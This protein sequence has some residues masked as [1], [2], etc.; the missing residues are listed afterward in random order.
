MSLE[1]WL[2]LVTMLAF[3]AASVLPGHAVTGK[4]KAWA[5]F[6]SAAK[7][8]STSNRA[9]GIRALGLLRENPHAREL[10]EAALDDEKPEVRIA[11]AT[12]L[13]Q[14]HA[15]QSI[16]KLQKLLA[17]E[18]VGVVMAAAHS[19]RDLKDNSSAYAVYYDVLTGAK[20]GDGPIAQQLDTLRNPRELAK[21]GFEEGIGYIPFAGIGWDAWRYTHKKD[22]NPVRAVAA[23]L[24]AHDPDPATGVAL[25][26]AM[27]DKD[28]IVRAAAIEALAQRGDPSVVGKIEFKLF[29]V[30]AH[31]RYTAAAAVI[32]LSALTQRE[33]ANRKD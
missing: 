10:A 33:V 22:P 20:K 17:D 11:A 19:L 2:R 7:S 9:A 32:R 29:D 15:T 26:D 25:T 31:V 1:S 3:L 6:E 27:K 4:E 14:M 23:S 28:W 24:L 8:T 18:K 16:A 13:G 5:M 21:I 12:A 30:N